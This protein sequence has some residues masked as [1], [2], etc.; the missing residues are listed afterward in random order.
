MLE[1]AKFVVDFFCNKIN[2]F[3]PASRRHQ[4]KS[5]KNARCS[6]PSTSLRMVKRNSEQEECTTTLSNNM[7]ILREQNFNF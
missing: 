6:D 4:L 3:Q 1:I 2:F 5:P 7:N